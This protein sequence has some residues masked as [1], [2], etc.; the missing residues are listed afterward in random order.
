MCKDKFEKFDKY[1]EEHP[2]FKIEEW[3]ALL[4]DEERQ[5]SIEKLKN[6]VGDE[7]FNSMTQ[8]EIDTELALNEMWELAARDTTA[9]RGKFPK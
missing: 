4:T 3:M 8:A 1:M 9:R 6:E 7:K 2:H 5:H